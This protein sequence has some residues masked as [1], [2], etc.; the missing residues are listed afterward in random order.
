MKIKKKIRNRITH[1]KQ[2]FLLW[3]NERAKKNNRKF[4]L[5]ELKV[6]IMRKE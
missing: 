2:M 4:L 1:G 5:Q 3:A 6:N